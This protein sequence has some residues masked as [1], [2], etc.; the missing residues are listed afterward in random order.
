LLVVHESRYREALARWSA[1]GGDASRRST[2]DAVVDAVRACLDDDLDTP[3]AVA[4]IDAG[5]GD[6]TDA[7]LLLGVDLRMFDESLR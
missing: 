1:S 7:A 6:V 4:A 3:G 5:R 2:D